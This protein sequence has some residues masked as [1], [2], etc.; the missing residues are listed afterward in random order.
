MNETNT[1]AL[2]IPPPNAVVEEACR[3]WDLANQ[4]ADKAL[5]LALREAG[6]PPPQTQH[7]ACI[8]TPPRLNRSS[9]E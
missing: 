1:Q 2:V 4:A 6:L 5:I 9:F 8:Q 7:S 3:R